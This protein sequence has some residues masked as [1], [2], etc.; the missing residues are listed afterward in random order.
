MSTTASTGPVADYTIYLDLPLVAQGGVIILLPRELPEDPSVDAETIAAYWKDTRTLVAAAQVSLVEL[1]YPHGA[2]YT[3]RFRSNREQDYPSRDIMTDRIG[4]GIGTGFHPVTGETED[5]PTI[6]TQHIESR[7]GGWT[8]EQSRSVR[9]TAELGFPLLRY[10]CQAFP[11]S[12]VCA[13]PVQE[14]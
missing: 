14:P 2:S 7:D 1:T 13:I 5:L 6:L 4:V 10:A 12:L 8:V 3:Y 9:A 11:D